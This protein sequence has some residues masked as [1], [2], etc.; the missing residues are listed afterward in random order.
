MRPSP[1]GEKAEL[2]S[3]YHQNAAIFV[4]FSEV[5][6]FLSGLEVKEAVN[7]F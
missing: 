6:H 5:P 2:P 3:D 4:T 1:K 7:N